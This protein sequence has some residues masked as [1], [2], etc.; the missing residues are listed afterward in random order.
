[1]IA[2]TGMYTVLEAL[3]IMVGIVAVVGIGALGFWI[4]ERE[5]KDR[6]IIPWGARGRVEKSKAHTEVLGESLKQ[7]AID[8]KRAALA[9]QRNKV[10]E[11]IERDDTETVM[12]L[13]LPSGGNGKVADAEWSPSRSY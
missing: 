6:P 11:A 4:V 8:V 13:G 1:M 7:D 9:H 5:N 10:L 12:L 2:S 3:V